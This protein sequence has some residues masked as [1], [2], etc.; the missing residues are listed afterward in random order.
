MD[1]YFGSGEDRIAQAVDWHMP[2][3]ILDADDLDLLVA[4]VKKAL[5][6]HAVI[7]GQVVALCARCD[8]DTWLHS[9]R[10]FDGPCIPECGCRQFVSVDEKEAPK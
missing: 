2:T 10:W 9:F 7:D 8:H 6:G 1:D 5:E 4:E 3:S